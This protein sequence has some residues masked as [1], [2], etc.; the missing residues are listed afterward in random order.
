M[1]SSQE[2]GAASARASLSAIE[3]I[4]HRYADSEMID[5]DPRVLIVQEL[6]KFFTNNPF[7]ID[8]ASRA[9]LLAI[10]NR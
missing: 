9:I 7:L 5:G 8:K 1:L 10:S 4:W 3:N 6:T 2:S